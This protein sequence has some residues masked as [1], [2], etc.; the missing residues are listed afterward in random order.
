LLFFAKDINAQNELLIDF[1][2][3]PGATKTTIFNTPNC[4]A[5]FNQTNGTNAIEGLNVINGEQ[6]FIGLGTAINEFNPDGKNANGQIGSWAKGLRNAQIKAELRAKEAIVISRKV[7]IEENVILETSTAI[8][9]GKRPTMLDEG[10]MTTLEKIKFV[11]L[12]KLDEVLELDALEYEQDRREAAVKDIIAQDRF[13][14][15]INASAYA[16][17]TG[18]QTVYTNYYQDKNEFCVI[19][20]KN[21][22]SSLMA[23]ALGK[24]KMS[25]LKAD[26]SKAGATL[27]D[28]IEG[29]FK[30]LLFTHG[31]RVLRDE[32]GELALIV[33]VV[34]PYKQSESKAIMGRNS[35]DAASIARLRAAALVANFIEE[36]INV[37]AKTTI[38]EIVTTYNGKAE[39]GSELSE[40]FSEDNSVNRINRMTATDVVGFSK[41]AGGD[42]INDISGEPVYIYIGSISVTSLRDVMRS[43]LKGTNREIY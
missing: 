14:S 6:I 13:Q 7:S 40:Y 26:E 20:M 32:K 19:V 4:M 39:D 41:Q 25:L 12:Q 24:N 28:Q 16:E 43:K 34:E 1:A 8:S 9:Q 22:D 11:I 33:H 27:R 23:K 38:D 5:G 3:T 10:E 29:N 37:E 21:N 42:Y 30:R 18:M 36:S 17:M 31:L 35:K 15:V 2:E